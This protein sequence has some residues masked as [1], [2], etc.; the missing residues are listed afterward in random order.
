MAGGPASYESFLRR[1]NDLKKLYFSPKSNPQFDEEGD[2]VPSAHMSK[3][4]ICRVF[5]EEMRVNVPTHRQDPPR[6]LDGRVGPNFVE[7]AQRPDTIPAQAPGSQENPE[8]PQ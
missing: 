3:A 5:L 2:E 1:Y 8:L 7:T 4:Q 6:F